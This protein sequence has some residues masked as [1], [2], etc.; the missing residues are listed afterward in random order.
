MLASMQQ[1]VQGLID[2]TESTY[3]APVICYVQP[4][5]PGVVTAPTAYV[6]GSNYHQRR[7]NRYCNYNL[8]RHHHQDR[9]YLLFQLVLQHQHHHLQCHQN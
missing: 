3:L 1:Y 4:P 8:H 9:W 6:W 2:G 7:Q 5:N